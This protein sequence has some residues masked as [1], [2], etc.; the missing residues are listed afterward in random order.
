MIE[1][2][3]IV[4]GMYDVTVIPKLPLAIGSAV[5]G[6]FLKLATLCSKI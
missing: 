3:K 2:Y 1:M 6:N 5:R 4:T